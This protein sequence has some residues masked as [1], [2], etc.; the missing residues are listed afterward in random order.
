MTYIKKICGLD[1]VGRGALAGPVVVASVIFKSYSNIPLGIKDSKKISQNIRVNLFNKIKE[2]LSYY[3]YLSE[4][5]INYR[6]CRIYW[7]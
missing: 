1:E 7:I 3:H 5:N 2:F 4:K 6:L